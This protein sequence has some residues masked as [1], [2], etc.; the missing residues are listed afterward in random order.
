MTA[1][2]LNDPQVQQLNDLMREKISINGRGNF[3]TLEV[4]LSDLVSLV[5]KKLEEDGVAVQSILLNGSGASS[6]LAS[7]NTNITYN[8][9]DLIF[10]V[11]LSNA[12]SFDKVKN[13]VM[14][15][16]LDLLPAGVSKL[17][18]SSCALK[19][20]Y[21]TK[22][23]KVTEKDR[24]SL[25]ALGNNKSKSVEL[26]FVSSMKRQYEF[27]ID[28][29][30]IMLGNLFLFYECCSE[31]PI[32]ENFYP[33]VVA[34]SVYGDFEEA[35]YHLHEK[36][37]ASKNPA[38]IRG[39]GLL[40]Y[41]NLLC[42][43]YQPACPEEVEISEKYMCSRFFIDFPTVNLQKTKL[44]KYLCAHFQTL[45]DQLKYDYLMILYQV[46]FK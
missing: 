10:N 39:G 41:C 11:D 5:N 14:A 4:R 15:T 24:W 7:S 27:S 17:R 43:G 19:E 30:H 46:S 20:A 34:E 35:M 42:Q 9:L 16:L 6:V 21:V 36:L 26:K 28:S 25:I 23:V 12:K 2:I 45:E 8:D 22:M 38:E 3:P 18:M 40:K 37:I 1:R 29:F 31:A 13:A 32:T 44:E 33:T